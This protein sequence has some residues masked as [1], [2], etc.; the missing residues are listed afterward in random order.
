MTPKL[1]NLKIIFYL[2]FRLY[3]LN[4]KRV[5]GKIF[6]SRCKKKL[7]KVQKEIVS[8]VSVH[9]L[10]DQPTRMNVKSMGL[11]SYTS[12]HFFCTSKIFLNSQKTLWSFKETHGHHIPK[13]LPDVDFRKSKYITGSRFLEVKIYHR[14]LISESQNISPEVDFRKSKYIT[15][16]QLPEVKIYHRKIFIYLYL[17][18][19]H[20]FYIYIYFS[21][22]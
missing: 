3:N 15:G 1:C 5:K 18:L 6:I 7:M 13:L 17:Y 14:K 19:Y 20:H 21:V 11:S 8:I 12:K 4:P 9:L 2:T 22:Y 10:L 16:S